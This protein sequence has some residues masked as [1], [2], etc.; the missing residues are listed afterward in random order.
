MALRR[1]VIFLATADIVSYG[2]VPFAPKEAETTGVHGNDERIP[3]AAFTDGVRL[4]YEVVLG[5]T[6]AQ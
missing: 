6:K 3:V 5:F 2:F 4:M 1:D